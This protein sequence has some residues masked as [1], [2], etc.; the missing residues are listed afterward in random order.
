M[1]VERLLPTS[2]EE[3]VTCDDL[4]PKPIFGRATGAGRFTPPVI[5]VYQWT[6][7]ALSAVFGR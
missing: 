7:V 3:L 4:H 6:N 5:T 1:M 2:S